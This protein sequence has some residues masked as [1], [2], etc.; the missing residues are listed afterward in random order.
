M[1]LYNRNLMAIVLLDKSTPVNQ[2]KQGWAG[3]TAGSAET[4]IEVTPEM[5]EAGVSASNRHTYGEGRV[6][7]DEDIVEKIWRT[8]EGA[9]RTQLQPT[10]ET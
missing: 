7:S 2:S 3:D 10:K 9:H 8:I 5:I 6:L 4:E 1:F